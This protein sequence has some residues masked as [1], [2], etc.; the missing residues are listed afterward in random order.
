[1]GAHGHWHPGHWSPQ[2]PAA[3]WY[4]ARWLWVSGYWFGS[5]YVDG[6]WRVAERSDGNWE[7]IEGEYSDAGVWTRGHWSPRG[8]A[9]AG[10]SWEPG[11]WDGEEW[12]EGFW[13]PS[14]R[15]GYQWVEGGYNDDGAWESGYWEPTEPRAGHVWIPG[16][17][18]GE[19][20]VGGYWVS[21]AEYAATDTSTWTPAEGVDDGW[22]VPDA[23]PPTQ[24]VEGEEIP[25]A[26][27]AGAIPTD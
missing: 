23:A 17:F 27:P 22:D 21:D 16:W 8:A 19:T 12:V 20:W 13:R 2:R 24:A 9:P 6:Y 5:A 14:G 18:D 11:F 26:L 4:G 3:A 10:Y 1:M 7:W 15:D 25:L